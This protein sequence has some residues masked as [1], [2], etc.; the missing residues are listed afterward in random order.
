MKHIYSKINKNPLTWFLVLFCIAYAFIGLYMTIRIALDIIDSVTTNG[1]ILLV[2]LPIILLLI[3]LAVDLVLWQIIGKEI[4]EISSEDI[5]VIH[6]GRIFKYKKVVP[7][8]SIKQ[9]KNESNQIDML[10]DFWFPK[11]QSPIKVIYD[12][13]DSIHIG[14]NLTQ[15]E[16]VDLL[17]E[18]QSVFPNI[19]VMSDLSPHRLTVNEVLFIIW[20]VGSVLFF[21]PAWFVV[22]II[23]E[24][25]DKEK[26]EKYTERMAFIRHNY[27]KMYCYSTEYDECCLCVSMLNRNDSIYESSLEKLCH[28]EDSLAHF[29]T[30][31]YI[32]PDIMPDNV[33]I[34]ISNFFKGVVYISAKYESMS[35]VYSN[36]HLYEPV[37]VLNKYLHEG[38]PDCEKSN[39]IIDNLDILRWDETDNFIN[40]GSL[41][42]L[43]IVD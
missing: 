28:A 42:E 7:V 13:D 15:T 4:V 24:R 36:N 20:A 9:I 12:Y 30:K 2:F 17:N 35:L 16:C 33:E 5:T 25:Q 34:P 22:P 18:L 41:W 19:E 29:S 37:F 43:G 21:I 10:R 3:L 23:Q 27:K 14:R 11:R 40:N 26:I 39:Y 1:I 32:S 6:T 31:P 38:I 8:A